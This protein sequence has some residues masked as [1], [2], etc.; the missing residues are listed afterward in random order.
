MQL[1]TRFLAP[2]GLAKHRPPEVPSDYYVFA[3]EIPWSKAF[4]R[5]MAGTGEVPYHEFVA[6]DSGPD[7]DVEILGHTYAWESYHSPLNE[8]GGVVVPSRASRLRSIY[9]AGRSPSTK[10]NLTGRW[11]PSHFRHPS[12]SKVVFCT[13]VRTCCTGTPQAVD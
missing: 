1:W 10:S 11:R 9:G 8:A 6:A 13:C 5:G 12:G 4:G 7:I 3:G 2:D